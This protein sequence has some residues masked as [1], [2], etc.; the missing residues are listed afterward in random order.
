M[1]RMRGGRRRIDLTINATQAAVYDAF[2]AAGNP[3]DV[4]D[5]VC[6]VNDPGVVLKAGF[7]TGVG[8]TAGSTFKLVIRNNNVI[9][10]LAG[11]VAVGNN[12]FGQGGN[13]KVASFT[14]GSNGQNGGD[15]ITLHIPITI[16]NTDGFIFGGGGQ[17]AGGGSTAFTDP[18]NAATHNGPGGG[19]GAG[20]GY[21]DTEGNEPPKGGY[22]GEKDGS[23]TVAANGGDGSAGGPGAGGN[24]GSYGLEQGGRGGDGGGWGQPGADGQAATTAANPYTRA[25]GTAGAAGRAVRTNGHA[26]TWLG[27]NNSTQVKGAVA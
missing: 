1:L 17:G 16:D 23:G 20:Q 5:V 10:G 18:P 27:G 8:W 21:R 15:A 6:T 25:P 9:A 26:V 13:A 7:T 2:V 24:G 11:G 3:G 14:G 19:G 4:V 22:A 12:G